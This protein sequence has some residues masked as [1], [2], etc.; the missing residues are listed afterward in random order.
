M[1]EISCAAKI[2]FPN[3]SWKLGFGPPRSVAAASTSADVTGGISLPIKPKPLSCRPDEDCCCTPPKLEDVPMKVGG[4][5]VHPKGKS[6]PPDPPMPKALS[7]K[8]F[9]LKW[10]E[11]TPSKKSPRSLESASSRS[12]GPGAGAGGGGNGKSLVA[13]KSSIVER[14][15]YEGLTA[16]K[17][18]ANIQPKGMSRCCDLDEPMLGR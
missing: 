3:P 7:K 1:R 18:F 13:S 12:E 17:L 9:P 6:Y 4:S 5:S 11:L 15:Q 10:S 2:S 8:S 16:M 14:S